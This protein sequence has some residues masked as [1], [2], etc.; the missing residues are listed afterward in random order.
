MEPD[1][2]NIIGPIKPGE[3]L[4]FK[5]ENAGE[6]AYY[7]RQALHYA[8]K[9][10]VSPYN[11]YHVTLRTNEEDTVLSITK[12]K[13]WNPVPLQG[14]P[15]RFPDIYSLSDLIITI[16]QYPTVTEFEF[17]NLT[18]SESEEFDLGNWCDAMDYIYVPD[19]KKIEKKLSH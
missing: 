17:P 2:I 6:Y 18:L 1:L 13:A 10:K 4:D 7:L 11:H 8:K 19:E 15:N 16:S 3:T 14:I 12:K 9:H 5:V